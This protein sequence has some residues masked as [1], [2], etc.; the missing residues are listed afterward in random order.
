MT[1]MVAVPITDTAQMRSGRVQDEWVQIDNRTPLQ[2]LLGAASFD[3]CFHAKALA[4]RSISAQ[5]LRMEKQRFEVT[6]LAA[7]ASCKARP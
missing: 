2:R 5:S 3:F 4:A 1:A 7:C 6:L